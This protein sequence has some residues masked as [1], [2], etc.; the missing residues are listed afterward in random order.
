V[1]LPFIKGVFERGREGIHIVDP[2]F[3][4]STPSD[5][6]RPV[7]MWRR[8]KRAVSSSYGNWADAYMRDGHFDQDRMLAS[9]RSPDG[10]IEQ[11]FALTRLV[12]HWM[13]P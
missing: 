7:S 8:R 2:S 1:L 12:A 11:G 13:G 9:S 4:R 3:V 10:G 5:S 6:R